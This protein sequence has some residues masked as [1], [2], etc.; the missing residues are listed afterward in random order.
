MMKLVILG[1]PGSG[2]GTIA[3][4]FSRKYNYKTIS[5]GEIL[6]KLAD[7]TD[8]GKELKEKYWGAGN[9]VPDDIITNILQKEVGNEK[10]IV[11]DG[12]PRTLAQAMSLEKLVKIDKVIYLDIPDE[13][14]VKRLG[15]RRQCQQCSRIYHIKMN[16][17]KKIG[18]CDAD[19]ARLYIRADDTPKVIMERL[20]IYHQQ[21]SPLI[22]YYTEKNMILR[23]NAEQ[24]IKRVV[25]DVSGLLKVNSKV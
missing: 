7:T 1:A 24:E 15:G 14:I 21:I 5:T 8:L 11:F 9:L 18:L 10:D 12:Y 2:K 4:F 6:R 16:P 13:A 22:A 25:R 23:V 17:P 20:R 3:E 19:G